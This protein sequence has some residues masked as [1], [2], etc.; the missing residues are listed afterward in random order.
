MVRS[1]FL[2]YNTSLTLALAPEISAVCPSNSCLH[3]YPEEIA[4]VLL[5][6]LQPVVV[7]NNFRTFDICNRYLLQTRSLIMILHDLL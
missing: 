3:K 2:L 4:E 1:V 7:Y 6:I 5:N